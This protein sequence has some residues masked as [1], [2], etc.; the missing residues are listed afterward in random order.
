MAADALG[1]SPLPGER[2]RR[3][4]VAILFLL[5]LAAALLARTWM[6]WANPYVDG[7]KE[8]RIPERVARGERLYAD[9]V[10]HYGPVPNWLH[11]GAY[12]LLG[13]RYTTPLALLIPLSALLFGSLFALARRAAGLEAAAWGAAW[14]ITLALVA[15]NGGALVL[16]Y[17]YAG[18]HSLALASLGLFLSLSERRTAL[19]GAAACWALALASKQEYALASM[20]ASLVARAAGRPFPRLVPGR[21]ALAAAGG[22]LGGVGLFAWALRGLPLASLAPE[23]PMVLFHL[24]PEWRAFFRFVGGFDEPAGSLRMLA[25]SAFLVLLLLALVEAAGRLEERF[26]AAGGATSSR[27]ALLRGA[28]AAGLLAG[29]AF[30]LVS[31]LG[32]ELDKAFP[33]LLAVVPLASL[34]V[35]AHALLRRRV[36]DSSTNARV[37]LL[38]FAGL[39]SFRVLL[40]VTYGWVSTPFTA[41][42]APAL[43]TA[44]AATCFHS[45]GRRRAYVALCFSALAVLQAG[46]IWVQS[47]PGRYAQVETAAGSL[48]LSSSHAG[49]TRET[50]AFLGREAR[51]GDTLAGLPEAG[52]FNFALGL[53]NPMRLEQLLPGSL[54]AAGE[55]RFFRRLHEA[56]PR[57]LLIPNQPTPLFGPV[58]FGRDW[59]QGIWAVVASDYRLRAQAGD[60]PPGA[61]VGSPGF[62]IRIYERAR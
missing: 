36:A 52:L 60:A 33:A 15:P 23:G 3:A 10:C 22:V 1:G 16:P 14:G 49:A 13:Y 41:F 18:T 55:A 12:R 61:P 2:S 42:A 7:S 8:L 56:G 31:P 17:S 6:T 21:V 50:L 5:L 59:G 37:A 38:A 35:A 47:D 53:P 57:F 46:R 28:V 43:A 27:V 9:V 25:S 44:A 32:R 62:F 40:R 48:R 20:G 39:A 54:D 30:L 26:V 4:G 34:L 29:V 11:A 51:P 24:P 19:A 45:L 58:A